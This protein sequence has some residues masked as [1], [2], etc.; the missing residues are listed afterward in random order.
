MK[1]TKVQMMEHAM[2]EPTRQTLIIK[3]IAYDKR[4]TCRVQQVMEIGKEETAG[5]RR[6]VPTQI[7]RGAAA[8]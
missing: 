2:M 7:A 8:S 4:N 6:H 5:G 1:R 3:K